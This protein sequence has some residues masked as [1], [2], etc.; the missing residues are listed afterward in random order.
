LEIYTENRGVILNNKILLIFIR[1]LSLALSL[2]AAINFI[3]PA[4]SINI[5]FITLF[6]VFIINN[7]FRFFNFRKKTLYFIIS[8]FIELAL[9][10]II[11]TY[12]GGILFLLLFN[13]LLDIAI[14]IKNKYVKFI[15]TAVIILLLIF[16][17]QTSLELTMSIVLS[18][19]AVGA[20]GAFINEEREKKLEAQKLYDKLRISEEE[21]KNAKEEL[22][23]YA[24]TIEELT[25]LRER[26]RISRE[27]HD[28][29]GHSLSTMIIQLAAIEKIADRDGKTA[30]EM[31]GNLSEFAKEALKN[32]RAAV[33]ALKPREFERYQGILAIEEMIRNFKKL[34]EVEVIFSISKEKWELNS[35]QSFII[36]RVVQ[37]FLTNSVRHGKATKVNINLNFFQSHLYMRL[38]DN[39]L[40]CKDIIEGIGLKSIKERVQGGGGT[41]KYNSEE[42][43]GF[44][45]TLNLSREEVLIKEG[46]YGED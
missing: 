23:I 1:Y 9:G 2:A 25:L 37:E 29:V 36:Y 40:G 31:A 46:K 33:K 12:Y 22:E 32:V 11:F 19:A 14:N 20:L 27:I 21:L 26:N 24:S 45:L 6:L 43:K 41:V 8:I 13:V 38:K 39:G 16:M 44:E 42:N 30:S 17:G 3:K 15:L 7:Q 35:D 5:Y 10:I 18:A 28:S 34:T 4:K